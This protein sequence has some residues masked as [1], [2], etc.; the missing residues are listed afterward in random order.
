MQAMPPNMLLNDGVGPEQD[1]SDWRGSES[2]AEEG[3]T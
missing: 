1:K 3:G 2:I